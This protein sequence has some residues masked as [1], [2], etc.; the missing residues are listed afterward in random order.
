MVCLL[1]SIP[2]IPGKVNAK[3]K[4]LA[5]KSIFEKFEN[6]PITKEKSTQKAKLLPKTIIGNFLICS[7]VLTCIGTKQTR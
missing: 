6:P 3:R 4:N 2:A 7:V 1:V 5:K